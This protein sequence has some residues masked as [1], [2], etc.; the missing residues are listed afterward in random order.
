MIQTWYDAYP[1]QSPFIYDDYT[2]I[3]DLLWRNREQIARD[4]WLIS[5]FVQTNSV[6]YHV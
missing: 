3:C 6:C 4:I 2:D 5:D 1:I